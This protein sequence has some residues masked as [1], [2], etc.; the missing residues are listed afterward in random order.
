M[1][2]YNSFSNIPHLPLQLITKIVGG[3]GSSS[4]MRPGTGSYDLRRTCPC[5]LGLL[6]P[7]SQV[8]PV[9]TDFPRWHF[10]LV[11][12]RCACWSN[13]SPSLL[14]LRSVDP[15]WCVLGDRWKRT[16]SVATIVIE[17]LLSLGPFICL[18]KFFQ[19]WPFWNEQFS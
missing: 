2:Q 13:N 6:R 9:C 16:N 11:G 4:S 18:S 14:S 17:F 7:R 3:T 1:I 15:N 19:I 8:S 12:S 10:H 5:G